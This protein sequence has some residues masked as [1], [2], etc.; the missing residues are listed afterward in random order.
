[1]SFK[2]IDGN[3]YFA[4][5]VTLSASTSDVNFPP[6][7]LGTFQRSKVWRS[8]P[9]GGQF[10]I[11]AAT[12]DKIDFDEGGGEL[13]ATLVAGTFTATTLQTEIKT[14]M[15]AAGADTY[16]V[17]W[18]K[19]TGKWT[20]SSTGTFS[21]PI[22]TGTNTATNVLKLSLGFA[23]SDLTSASSHTGA[24][25][26]IHTEE[27]LILDLST[28]ETISL[29]ALIEDPVNNF[30]FSAGATLKIE[31]NA[32]NVWTSPSFSTT[33]T[34]DTK[35]RNALEIF[36]PAQTL[37]FWSIEII[38]PTNPNLFV[39]LSKAFLDDPLELTQPPDIGFTY[40][41]TDPSRQIETPFGHRYADSF[42]QRKTL[43]FNHTALLEADQL[44]LE[45]LFFNKGNSI[46]IAVSLDSPELIFTDK[47]QFFLYG[48]IDGAF[49]AKQN[50]VNF[51]DVP[52]KIK[53]A[54]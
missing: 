27:R 53:E 19:S 6:S 42:P 17:L 13:T 33:F 11:T 21:L 32:T 7:N 39:E 5:G 36:S 37:R 4:D 3:F 20:I 51:W 24:N 14:R 41:T 35:Y 49:T 52:F 25:I 38:D 15:D 50:F 31:G 28:T 26:A 30:Q 45:T 43:S 1:M 44:L 34:I 47:N 12:N 18:S 16:T 8:D 54:I 48:Y 23:N 22:A 9:E 29:F 10:I 40:V 46:P 2:I